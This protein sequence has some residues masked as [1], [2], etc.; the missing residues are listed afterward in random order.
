MSSSPANNRETIN[1]SNTHTIISFNMM[2]VTKFTSTNIVMWS[3]QLHALFGGYDL[4]GYIDGCHHLFPALTNEGIVTTNPDVFFTS[5]PPYLLRFSWSDLILAS[6][7]STH[8]YNCGRDLDIRQT[9]S[10]SLETIWR[11]NW[12]I[13]RKITRP[14]MIIFKA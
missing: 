12:N 14:L 7:Y 10:C 3:R 11:I 2:N 13:W 8:C 6:A 9:E 5:R 4:A 1:V